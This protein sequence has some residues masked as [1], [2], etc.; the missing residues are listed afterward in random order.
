VHSTRYGRQRKH[1]KRSDKLKLCELLKGFANQTSVAAQPFCRFVKRR[2]WEWATSLNIRSGLSFCLPCNPP[3]GGRRRT[4]LFCES[5]KTRSHIAFR[6]FVKWRLW[7]WATS[8]NIWSCLSFCPPCNPPLGGC[9]RIL[10]FCE[11]F[12]TRSRIAF[13]RFVK[14]RLWEWAT[15]FN[16]ISGLSFCPPCNPPLGGSDLVSHF[17]QRLAFLFPFSCG[18]PS[19]IIR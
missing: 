16:S 10:L 14:W 9:R 3:S 18:F 2:L 11:S 19:G 8:L 6:R 15:S 7:E 4:F 17:G 12:K 1:I 13:R 5:F